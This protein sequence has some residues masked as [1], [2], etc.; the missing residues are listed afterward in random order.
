MS[1][2]DPHRRRADRTTSL[3]ALMLV[4]LLLL[5]AGPARAQ[6]PGAPPAGTPVTARPVPPIDPDSATGRLLA[7]RET[8][9]ADR[10]LLAELRKDVPT[11]TQEG[12]TFVGRV[13]G[14][15]L[16]ADP[17]GLGVVA[18]RVRA[19]AP[20]WLEWHAQQYASP[21]EAAD[22]YAR[23]GAGAFDASW[24]ELHD[25][26]LLTVVNRLDTIIELADQI[27]VGQ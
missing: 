12:T 25:A 9:E 13:V 22:A 2:R 27:E 10:M 19:A 20:A 17:V 1:Q 6:S 4:P 16:A 24:E 8:L 14:L 23:L 26:A 15:A 21:Q 11:T 5:L 3:L 7:M 18:S